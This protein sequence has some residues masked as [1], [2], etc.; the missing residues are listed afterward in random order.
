M[1][2]KLIAAYISG[3]LLVIWPVITFFFPKLINVNLYNLF[4]LISLTLSII[5]VVQSGSFTEQ[6]N[7]SWITINLI[8]FFGIKE[9]LLLLY[10][11]LLKLYVP[12]W[13]TQEVNIY[14]LLLIYIPPIIILGVNLIYG[15]VK[16]KR[17]EIA[18][19]LNAR[20]LKRMLSRRGKV[21][22]E[23]VVIERTKA[24]KNTNFNEFDLTVEDN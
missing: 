13:L 15:F 18:N 2:K 16:L 11:S 5:V 21:E 10:T 22:K 19:T 7:G 1:N 8:L 23:N 3:G 12:I 24:T 17:H 14:L 20:M 4:F 6:T 9:F